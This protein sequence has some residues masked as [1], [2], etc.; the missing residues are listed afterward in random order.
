MLTEE[1]HDQE[2]EWDSRKEWPEDELFCES[3]LQGQK[4]RSIGGSM[5][6]NRCRKNKMRK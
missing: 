3:R 5:I 2:H 4:Q 6:A 1:R